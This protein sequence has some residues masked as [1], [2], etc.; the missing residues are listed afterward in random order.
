MTDYETDLLELLSKTHETIDDFYEAALTETEELPEVSQEKDTGM[1]YP[2]VV[3]EFDTIPEYQMQVLNSLC[4][5]SEDA[6]SDQDLLFDMYLK[7]GDD[8]I[9][10][11]K[12]TNILLRILYN[13]S[14]F[15][16]FTR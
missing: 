10:F 8:V 3:F 2:C 15:S 7:N 13:S 14:L 6:L 12:T 4:I 16:R 1:H 5:Q 9:A 11:G